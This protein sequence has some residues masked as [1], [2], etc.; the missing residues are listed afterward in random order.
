MLDSKPSR[1]RER[2]ELKFGPSN[3]NHGN[4]TIAKKTE[5]REA[6]SVKH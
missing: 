4:L 3:F 2:V 5:T 6:L 1:R